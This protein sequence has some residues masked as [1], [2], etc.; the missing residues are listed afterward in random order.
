[1]RI[2]INARFL[3][4]DRLEG[5]GRFTHEVSRRLVE[6]FPEHEFILLFDRPFDAQFIYG[7]NIR[8]VV[9][10]PP[11]RHPLLWWTWFEAS[12]PYVLKR[13]RADRFFSPDAY[14][15]L[16]SRVP[17][18]MVT[19]DLAHLHYPAQIPW[20]VNRYYQYFVP[21]YLQRAEAVI[22]VSEFCKRDIIRHYPFVAEKISVACNGVN[23]DFQP[24]SP[25]DQAEVRQRYSDGQPYFFYLGAVH[26]RK[27]VARLVAAFDQFKQESG[28]P[29]KLLIAGRLAWQTGALQ[30][31]LQLSPNEKDIR[32]LGY[33]PDAELPQLVG[34]ALGLTYVSLF[35]GFGVPLLE[36]MEAEVPILTSRVTSLPEVAGD[37]GILVDPTS[38]ADISRGLQQLAG[39]S[40]RERQ[41]LIA[42]GRIQRTRFSWERATEV[43]ANA[44]ELEA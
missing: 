43:V 31:A 40:D 20:L 14:C 38:V 35:E 22:T 32:L 28:S 3:L 34:S 25:A 41:A 42:R 13:E 44:L 36:A 12:I 29:A 37:A 39:L 11:A 30:K 24:L 5:I 17:T 18:V 8:P 19:H 10:S 26:P 4:P 21:H 6:Q 2:A 16:R 23:P 7:P 27:N 9:V 15:S 33:V 1:M